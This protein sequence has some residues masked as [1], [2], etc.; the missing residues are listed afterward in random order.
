MQ[1]EQVHSLGRR[2]AHALAD[3]DVPA[4]ESLLAD[5][6]DFRALT[7]KRAWE[8]DDRNAVL[9]IMLGTWFAPEDEIE[10]LLELNENDHVED[11]A[12]VGYRFALNTPSGPHTTE[13]Q[14]YYRV[15]GEQISYLRVLCSGFRPAAG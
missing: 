7:P 5:P 6:I 8:A 3:K 11:T 9:E 13:Q 15:A 1:H 14:A 12:H 10:A 2:F 4:L